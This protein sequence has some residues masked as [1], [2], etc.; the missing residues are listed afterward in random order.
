[1]GEET[2][3]VVSGVG[4]S[5][6]WVG[7]ME[8]RVNGVAEIEKRNEESVESKERGEGGEKIR[9][10]GVMEVEEDQTEG[11]EVE[12][13]VS[14]EFDLLRRLRLTRFGISML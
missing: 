6:E 2:E 7:W 13:G 11:V 4:K 5:V 8:K 9:G 12:E 10:V 1:M 3:A 14:L